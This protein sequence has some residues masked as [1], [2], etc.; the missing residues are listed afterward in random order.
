MLPAAFDD[1]PV[2]RTTMQHVNETAIRYFETVN[3]A[4]TLHMNTL[5]IALDPLYT[6]NSQTVCAV[7]D[8]LTD[9]AL[10]D[11][12]H[13]DVRIDVSSWTTTQ[14]TLSVRS[15]AENSKIF[16]FKPGCE[17][18]AIPLSARLT[19]YVDV[20][21]Y[22]DGQKIGKQQIGNGQARSF[23]IF[24][25]LSEKS[26]V[27]GPVPI[28]VSS[29]ATTLT[30][31][32]RSEDK[33]FTFS[34]PFFKYAGE[35]V[36]CAPIATGYTVGC[37]FQ[38]FNAV[39]QAPVLTPSRPVT[40]VSTERAEAILHEC[41]ENVLKLNSIF[42]DVF[43]KTAQQ[44]FGREYANSV[45]CDVDWSKSFT[46]A[47]DVLVQELITHAKAFYTNLTIFS[48]TAVDASWLTD[49]LALDLLSRRGQ[50]AESVQGRRT[51]LAS[52]ARVRCTFMCLDAIDN[53]LRRCCRLR[54]SEDTPAGKLTTA[55]ETPFHMYWLTQMKNNVYN[56]VTLDDKNYSDACNVLQEC[57]TLCDGRKLLPIPITT[58]IKSTLG[59]VVWQSMHLQGLARN[60]VFCLAPSAHFMYKQKARI[61]YTAHPV[62]AR[63]PTVPLAL[64]TMLV[65]AD[66]EHR[67]IPRKLGSH[68]LELLQNATG[69]DAS[70]ETLQN[71]TTFLQGVFDT[72][73][74]SLAQ[75]ALAS[76]SAQ[77]DLSFA[78]GLQSTGY[79]MQTVTA[80]CL[81]TVVCDKM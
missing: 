60:H 42:D 53:A 51:E 75:A 28:T 40:C 14:L 39:L 52:V 63:A 36:E 10:H 59:G 3:K 58:A 33:A 34:I 15:P 81:E 76:T 77:P 65:C 1:L 22:N 23:I 73:L 55:L 2:R 9:A 13:V 48:N 61:D 68:I 11:G 49:K 70:T 5:R 24:K 6:C 57:K 54:D 18:P 46:V 20:Q 30:A 74:H 72:S 37:A 43:L 45:V 38:D 66:V 79:N 50:L 80:F 47:T 19:T 29:G 67:I 35:E 25:D 32:L 31:L 69:K 27:D 26:E 44:E 12:L 16:V 64:L 8:C 4:Q 71:A 62:V 17:P 56:S 7:P 41:E 78:N 21:C